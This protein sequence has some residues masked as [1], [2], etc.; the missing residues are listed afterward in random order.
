V[1]KNESK[2]GLKHP[3]ISITRGVKSSLGAC[4][5]HDCVFIWAAIIVSCDVV[6]VHCTIYVQVWSIMTLSIKVWKSSLMINISTC[7]R[8]WQRKRWETSFSICV[9]ISKIIVVTISQNGLLYAHSHRGIEPNG[10][11]DCQW[12]DHTNTTKDG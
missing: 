3:Y 1:V 11:L 5:P 2:W 7:H 6:D 4:L 9:L 10:Y 12:Y 8:M